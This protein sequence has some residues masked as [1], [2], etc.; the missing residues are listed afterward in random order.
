MTDIA[1]VHT[2]DGRAFTGRVTEN[3]DGTVTVYTGRAGRPPH[4]RADQVASIEQHRAPRPT[5][6]QVRHPRP[7]AGRTVFALAR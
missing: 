4:L 5:T 2:T 3:A 1:T 7:H 6:G